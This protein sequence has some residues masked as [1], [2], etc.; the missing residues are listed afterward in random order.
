MPPNYIYDFYDKKDI[1]I[2]KPD[3]KIKPKDTIR[4]EKDF[5]NLMFE[6]GYVLASKCL[7][8]L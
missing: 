7:S 3:I 5:L 4:F 6:R 1:I 8:S 2:L